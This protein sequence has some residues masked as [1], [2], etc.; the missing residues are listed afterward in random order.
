MSTGFTAPGPI[1]VVKPSNPAAGADISYT[2]TYPALLV[3]VYALFTASATAA[4]RTSQLVITDSAGATLWNGQSG[5]AVTASGASGYSWSPLPFVAAG[6][7]QLLPI[8]PMLILPSGAIIKTVT[9][10]IQTGDQWSVLAFSLLRDQ[11]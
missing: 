3:G 2:L 10:N 6:P 9:A 11:F 5:S 1:T 8:P 7:P 4:S